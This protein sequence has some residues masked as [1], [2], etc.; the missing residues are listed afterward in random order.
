[1]IQSLSLFFFFVEGGGGKEGTRR[2]SFR[3]Q[4]GRGGTFGYGNG[5]AECGNVIGITYLF[6]HN[7]FVWREEFFAA[8]F[9]FFFFFSPKLVFCFAKKTFELA[10]GK[11]L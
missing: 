11:I 5:D 9:F 8:L 2:G 1:M 7:F 6:D 10:L 3:K 4:R